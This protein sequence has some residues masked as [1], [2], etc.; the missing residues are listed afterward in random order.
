MEV[1]SLLGKI[2]IDATTANSTIDSIKGKVESLGTVVEKAG[3]KISGIG[4]TLTKTVTTTGTALGVAAVK[5]AMTYEDAMAKINTIANLTASDAEVSYGEMEK[6]IQDLSNQTGVS[7]S[8]IAEDVYNAISAGQSVGDAVNFVSNS[9][10]LAKA[11]FAETGQSLDVLTTIMN[12]YGLEASEVT[13]VSDIL[14]QTQNLGKTTVGDLSATMGKVIPTAK[15]YNVSLEQVASGYTIM[16]AKGIATAETTTYMNSMLNELGKSGTKVSDVLKE[17]TGKSF[18]DL[19]N[20]GYTLGDCLKIVNQSAV[21]QNLSFMDMWGSAEAAKAGI[22]LLGDSSATFNSRLQEMRE[23]T[24]STDAAFEKLDTTSLK[25]TKVINSAKNTLIDLGGTIIEMTLPYLEKAAAGVEK[26]ATW[27]GNLD[28]RTKKLIVT[29]GGIA[30]AAGPV[31]KIVGSFVSGIGG[32]IKA[33]SN[34]VP[35]IGGTVSAGKTLVNGIGTL[36]KYGGQVVHGIGSKAIPA[37]KLLISGIGSLMTAGGKLVAGI[38]SKLIP[39]LM[40]FGPQGAVIA[41]VVAGVAFIGVQVYKHWDDIGA[42]LSKTWDGIKSGWNN[43]TTS[44]GEGIQSFGENA[45]QKFNEIKESVVTSVESMKEGAIAKYEEMKEKATAKID[46]MKEKTAEKITQMKENIS[47]KFTA[48]KEDAVE[49][50][51]ALK[52]NAVQS[53]ETMKA[54][55]SAKVHDLATGAAE[56]FNELKT[57]ASEKVNA[58]KEESA[59][60]FKELRDGAV[61]QIG[62]LKD[63]AVDGFHKLKES[64]GNS[65]DTLKSEATAK[66]ADIATATG[67]KF[68]AVGSGLLD[69]FAGAREKLGE[70]VENIKGFFDFDWKFPE[71]KLPHFKVEWDDSGLFGQAAQALGLQGIPKIGVEWY[72]DGG[73]MLNP[74]AFAFNPSTGN[75]MAGGEAG[76]EAIAPISLLQ[77]YIKNAVEESNGGLSAVMLNIYSLLLRYLPELSE[78]QMVLDTGETVGALAAPMGETLGKIA[79]R[80]ERVK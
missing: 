69:V 37:G 13:K 3:S 2:A 62:N 67:E 26:F 59:Q 33:G 11:G 9:T 68:A 4:S 16:T 55:I 74:T 51:T 41:A 50:V 27:F 76:P 15:S 32:I 49:K 46:E 56:K 10:K 78:M 18:T 39:M 43:L 36:L 8:A 31:L 72:K 70:I 44:I 28:E 40:S 12:A 65:I 64:A 79:A 73:I 29:I 42:F 35:L 52:D 38:G 24:G 77:D 66:I 57:T 5:S 54:D 6:A 53:F 61:E 14:I 19:M 7:A 30:I 60:K 71:I 80:R 21:E 48:L 63:S 34:I 58:L 23:S 47:E 25:L 1:F 20:E 22:T 17:K 75:V 45:S